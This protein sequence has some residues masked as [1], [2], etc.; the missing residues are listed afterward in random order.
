VSF[1]ITARDLTKSNSLQSRGGRI[2]PRR[3]GSPQL[4]HHE[5][6]LR[7]A[8]DKIV[9]SILAHVI[10]MAAQQ[11]SATSKAITRGGGCIR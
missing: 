8:I 4:F 2:L 11:T 5:A 1:D 10:A 7:Q 3:N 9:P 6:G